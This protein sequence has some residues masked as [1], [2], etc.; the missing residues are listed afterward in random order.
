MK[1]RIAALFAVLMALAFSLSVSADSS[2]TNGNV[3]EMAQVAPSKYLLIDESNGVATSFNGDIAVFPDFF[4]VDP[5]TGDLCYYVRVENETSKQ[6][7]IKVEGQGEM[8]TDEN[9]TGKITLKGGEEGYVRFGIVDNFTARKYSEYPPTG[10]FWATD[11]NCGDDARSSFSSTKFGARPAEKMEVGIGVKTSFLPEQHW[12]CNNNNDAFDY[13]EESGVLV[14]NSDGT[15]T[16]V[17]TSEN[18]ELLFRIIS[19]VGSST[20]VYDDNEDPDDNDSNDEEQ[21]Q[22]LTPPE[23]IDE[24]TWISFAT[25]EA[26]ENIE[27][28]HFNSDDSGAVDLGPLDFINDYVDLS[29]LD[30][31]AV[32]T[33]LMEHDRAVVVGIIALVI[34]RMLRN[35]AKARKKRDNNKWQ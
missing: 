30:L 26:F 22:D 25:P 7:T 16:F 21:E 3:S 23:P 32:G 19:T 1:R 13:D 28:M 10:K 4:G 14:A 6:M 9:P 11:A 5:D 31:N 27:P 20:D 17:G 24:M 2:D 29:K 35:S 18:N 8:F 34:L 15:I 33:F 12:S